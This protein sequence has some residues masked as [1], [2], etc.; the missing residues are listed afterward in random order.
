MASRLQRTF[1]N[2]LVAVTDGSRGNQESD[3]FH[4]EAAPNPLWPVGSGIATE[5]A[6]VHIPVYPVP[7][8]IDTTGAGDAFFGGMSYVVRRSCDLSLAVFSPLS[9][10]F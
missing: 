2:K 1:Q 6:A 3:A 8:V 5:H 9:R 7:K 10:F 4:L